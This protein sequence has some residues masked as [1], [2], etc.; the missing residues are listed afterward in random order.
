[1]IT[2]RIWVY[3]GILA[4]G[5][6]GPIDVFNAANL[7]GARKITPGPTPLPMFAW[8]AE[9]LGGQPVKAASGQG[10]PVDVKIDSRKRTDAILLTL[11]FFGH[12]R[13]RGR[14]G[15]VERAVFRV[16]APTQ[17]WC[18]VDLLAEAGLL[19]G[20]AATTPSHPLRSIRVM[21]NEVLAKMDRVFA[22]MHEADIKGAG[23]G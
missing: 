17:G 21:V 15:A 1:M 10:I 3:N 9:S 18:R 7:L 5:V 22:G 4:S 12:R 8:R 6:A 11:L 23:R 14:P 16:T 13:I 20:R 19:D 2:I